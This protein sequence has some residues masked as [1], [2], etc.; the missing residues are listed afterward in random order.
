MR[1]PQQQ[2]TMIHLEKH[3]K[4]EYV[5]VLKEVIHVINNDLLMTITNYLNPETNCQPMLKFI[6]F[7][8]DCKEQKF[9]RNCLETDIDKLEMGTLNEVWTQKY[10]LEVA[11]FVRQFIKQ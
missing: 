8:Q 11:K 1:H 6:K 7:L 4:P 9:S 5:H 3:N 2:K 10:V